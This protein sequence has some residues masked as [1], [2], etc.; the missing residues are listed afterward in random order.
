VA[1]TYE[2]QW[3]NACPACAFPHTGAHSVGGALCIFCGAELLAQA[4]LLA[5]VTRSGDTFTLRVGE[6]VLAA[7]RRV[8]RYWEITTE[9][10]AGFTL[11]DVMQPEGPE[12]ALLDDTGN[13][14]SS[15]SLVRSST[16]SSTLFVRDASE[17]VL[18][19]VRSDGCGGVHAVTPGGHVLFFAGRSSAD[20]RTV[21]L[22]LTDAAGAAP[23]V[24]LFAVGVALEV[25]PFGPFANGSEGGWGGRAASDGS[26][27]VDLSLGDSPSD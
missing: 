26:G 21:D 13:F 18:A 22:L 17:A 16:W 24:V 8:G 23:L 19:A 3:V 27:A 7:A 2:V 15:L 14:V 10:E 4:P 6:R 1:E 9:A 5:R 12:M 20:E 25:A 11:V